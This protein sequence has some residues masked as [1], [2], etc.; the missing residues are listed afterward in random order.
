MLWAVAARFHLDGHDMALSR[1]KFWYEG[2]RKM[3]EEERKPIGE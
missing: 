1:L 2:H 3:I